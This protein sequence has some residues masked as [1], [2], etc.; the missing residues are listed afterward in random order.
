[1]RCEWIKQIWLVSQTNFASRG[2]RQRLICLA[3]WFWH[4]LDY[5]T[6]FVSWLPKIVNCNLKKNITLYVIDTW[7]YKSCLQ[8]W[9]KR[10]LC[11]LA[12]VPYLTNEVFVFVV[13]LNH[14]GGRKKNRD[15]YQS[16]TAL[17]IIPPQ[18]WADSSGFPSKIASLTTCTLLCTI[19]NLWKYRRW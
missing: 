7:F 6:S 13:F 1:M 18:P 19:Y 3:H 8:K 4:V 14:Y 10:L 11:S 12:T 15:K 2:E 17:L 16:C 5:S 9:Q